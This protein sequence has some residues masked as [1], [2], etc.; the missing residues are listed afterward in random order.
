M[1]LVES[2]VKAFA[3]NAKPNTSDV[4]ADGVANAAPLINR[5]SPEADRFSSTKV[6]PST[7]TLSASSWSVELIIREMLEA[8]RT[9]NSLRTAMEPVT[10][11]VELVMVMESATKLPS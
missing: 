10:L 2:I 8:P 4:V 11:R 1:E 9:C 7:S 5:I 6:A 3:D